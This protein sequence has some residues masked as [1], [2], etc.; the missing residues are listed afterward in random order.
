MRCSQA[1][2]RAA[3]NQTPSPPHSCGAGAGNAVERLLPPWLPRS[4]SGESPARKPCRAR[5]RPRPRQDK[6]RTTPRRRHIFGVKGNVKDG[7][8]FLDDNVLVYVAG[9]QVI[10]LNRETHVQEF[11]AGSSGSR[12]I[13]ALAVSPSKT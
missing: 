9:H 4:P 3:E 12:G 7:L 2:V 10:K 11:I 13:T 1:V 5:A 8:H 6:A